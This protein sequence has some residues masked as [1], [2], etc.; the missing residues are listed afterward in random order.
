MPPVLLTALLKA[1][2]GVLRRLGWPRALVRMSTDEVH[3]YAAGIAFMLQ[4][5][6]W[7]LL[8]PSQP[9]WPVVH[10]GWVAAAADAAATRDAVAGRLHESD[11]VELVAEGPAG[12]ARRDALYAGA[13]RTIDI[14]SYYVQSDETGRATVQAL[15]ACVARGVRVR[16]LVDRFMT[17]KKTCEVPGMEA[18]LADIRAG[19]IEM[20]QWYDPVRRHDSNHRKMIVVD[21]AAALVGGRNFADHYRGNEWRDVDLVLEGPSVAPLAQLFESVWSSAGR[22]GAGPHSKSPWVDHVPAGIRTDPTM[23]FVLAAIG[24][25]E[26]RVEVELAY[27][28]AQ[29]PLIEALVQA[30]RRGVA[31]RLLTNS[32]ESTD[33]P[34]ATWTTYEGMRRLLEAG[35]AIHARRG[36]GRTLHCKYAVID[37]RWVSFGSHN[38]DYYSPRFCCETNLVVDDARLGAQLLAFFDTGWAA[39]TPMTLAEVLPYLPGAGAQRW[40]D[41]LFRDFQ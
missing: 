35:C 11:R 9:A 7:L 6:A 2:L 28:V 3:G 23:T 26:R 5:R 4:A 33:L 8:R 13:R 1:L 24:A 36:A 21:G 37:G 31:V 27:F 34:F 32:A 18:L 16:L 12:F 41:R 20:R 10:S 39:A 14:A 25:A 17:F 19:G 30:Q 29:E 40:F 15:V 38:L 22:T